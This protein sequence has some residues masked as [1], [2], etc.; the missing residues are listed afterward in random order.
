[1]K[2]MYL[3]TISLLTLMIVLIPTIFIYLLINQP[4]IKY[5]YEGET[6]REVSKREDFL[7]GSLMNHYHWKV[8]DDADVYGKVLT[9]QFNSFSAEYSLSMDEIWLGEKNYSFVWID[10]IASYAINNNLSL[11]GGHLLWH[12]TIPSWLEEGGY[13]N[14]EI[15]TLVKEYIQTVMIHFRT[16]FPGLVQVWNIVNEGVVHEGLGNDSLR[17]TFFKEKLGEDYIEKAFLWAHEADPNTKLFINE[18]GILG[19]PREYKIKADKLYALIKSLV[20]KE[21]PI[22]G[23]GFQGHISINTEHNM[24]YYKEQFD[25]FSNLGIECQITELDILINDDLEGKTDLKL[26]QQAQLYADIYEVCYS[27]PNCTGIILWG[28]SDKYTY[29]KDA[30]W[31]EQ[32]IDWPLLFDEYFNPKPAFFAV[33]EV[34]KSF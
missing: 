33:L 17:N 31:L 15:E 4:V 26:E 9:D 30:W 6:L 13:N 16:K 34:L 20:E 7:I 25:R 29:V 23:V 10:E 2:R 12:G 22:G 5:N 21:I 8:G 11:R 24:T 1:M 14:S 18:Y 19:N 32:D 3:V 28:L 27:H